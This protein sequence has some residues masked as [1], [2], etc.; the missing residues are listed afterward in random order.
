VTL[1]AVIRITPSSRGVGQPL[2]EI[3]DYRELL[4]FLAW[5]D[6]QVRYKQTALGAAWA[7]LQPVLTMVIFSLVFGNFARIPSDGLP[8]PL[9]VYC[10][11]VPWQLFAYALVNSSNSLVANERLITKVYFPRLVVPIGSVLAGVVDFGFCLI[12]LLVMM[13]YYGVRPGPGALAAPLFAA[14]ALLA[15]LAVGIGLS[16]LNV[17]F[18][19]VRYTLP[20]LTQLWLFATPIAYPASIVPETWRPWLGLN[21]MAAVVEG[22]RWSLLGGPPP[23]PQLL[24][25]TVLVVLLALA[26][27]LWGFL[28]VE[29]TFADVI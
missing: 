20:F 25:V 5:R 9:F 8:Y 17:W 23:S 3:W 18:R 16:A 19:D 13:G 14:L 1:P 4:V 12:L 29:R 11:L 2:R 6:I 22:F 10:G 7:I 26:I 28:H 24:L 15:A 27:S 21:P